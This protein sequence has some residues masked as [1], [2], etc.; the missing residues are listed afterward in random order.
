M[1]KLQLLLGPYDF[2]GQYTAPTFTAHP[3]IDAS[4]GEMMTMGYEARGDG[5]TDV[6][7]YL[8]SKEGK[9]LE[10]CWFKAPYIGMM[11]DMAATDKWV[12]FT[13]PPLQA[14]SLESLKAGSK[15]FAWAEDK[16][17][18]FGI[19]PRY[20]PKPEDIR[21][22]TY[23]NAFYGHT[24]NAFD[25]DDGCVYLDAPLTY[26]NKVRFLSFDLRLLIVV[27]FGSSLQS[28][29]TQ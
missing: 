13:I 10:E 7:Y 2:H 5:T 8:F 28:V 11:H 18:T 14:Q 21:W 24:G 3:K 19:L 26:F 22:F 16:P 27:S 15:H 6:A 20:N 23:K 25:G 1:T 12:V 9:K 29:K 17:L 4:N